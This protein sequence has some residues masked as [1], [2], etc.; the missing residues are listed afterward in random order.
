M[1]FIDGSFGKNFN[2]FGAYMSSSVYIDNKNK[3]ILNLCEGPTQRLDDT[4][5]TAEAKCPINFT[6]S[7]NRFLLSL[8]YNGINSFLFVSARKIYQLKTKDFEIKDYAVGLGKILQ[9]II[10][11]K[12]G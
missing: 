3:D 1:L 8:H 9:L 4:K 7:G 6:Q 10:W 12:Q 11:K 2:I 5:L